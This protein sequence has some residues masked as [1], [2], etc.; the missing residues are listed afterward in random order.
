M[1]KAAALLIG[2]ATAI[3][4]YADL[5]ATAKRRAILQ[6]HIR[7]YFSEPESSLRY[8]EVCLKIEKPYRSVLIHG[9]RP[10]WVQ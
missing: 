2:I 1:R 3:E 4:R 8:Y 10:P 7:E 9:I 6:G 5:R